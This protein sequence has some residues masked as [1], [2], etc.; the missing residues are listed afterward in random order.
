MDQDEVIQDGLDILELERS[1]GWQ[2][3]K[4]KLAQEIAELQEQKDIDIAGKSAETV[5]MEY[6]AICR[7]QEGLN[8][9]LEIVEEFK[10]A[11][12]QAQK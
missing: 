2:K 10:E 12:H 11:Y 1:P 3:V 9:T 7:R 4:A 8:R 6:V 5:G